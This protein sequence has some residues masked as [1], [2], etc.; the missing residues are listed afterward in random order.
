M[1]QISISSSNSIPQEEDIDSKLYRAASEG[2]LDLV[3]K[4]NF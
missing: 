4:P 3:K 2:Q 1:S